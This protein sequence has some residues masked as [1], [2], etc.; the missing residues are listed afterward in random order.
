[1]SGQLE[2]IESGHGCGTTGAADAL[3][4]RGFRV[5]FGDQIVLLNVTL[6]LR[7]RGVLTLLGPG[8]AGKS[9]LLRTLAGLNDP[10]PALRTWGDV[11]V[12]G[13]PIDA[14][15][16]P[17]LVG[18]NAQ[19]LRSSVRENLVSVLASR[20]RWSK[21]EQTAW[22]TQQLREGGLETL[23]EVL[24]SDVLDLPLGLRRRLAIVRAVAAGRS[25]VMID[26]PTVGLDPEQASLTLDLISKVAARVAILLVTHNR[27]HARALGDRTALLA[28]GV[29][30]ECQPTER[31][32]RAPETE[33]G[34]SY[35]LNGS[36]A[37]AG[38]MAKPD[39]LAEGVKPPTLLPAPIRRSLSEATGPQGFY[40][41][42]QGKVGGLPRPGIVRD[43]RHDLEG[44]A[45][46]GVT[47]LITLEE[48]HTVPL[49][50][51]RAAGIDHVLFPI[52]D[53]QVPTIGDTVELFGAVSRRVDEGAV[54]AFHCLAGLGRTGTLLASWLIYCGASAPEA[55]EFVRKAQPRSVQSEAQEEFLDRFA[56]AIRA[57]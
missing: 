42:E 35:V 49:A 3:S 39:E 28:G 2:R 21:P 43:L 55:L 41:A 12:L 8:G 11:R 22:V 38:P 57:T 5:A 32:F 54:V 16:R 50:Q 31:F 56:T 30:Q 13:E 25:V 46:L 18:Q 1:M 19:L 29:I 24:D 51:L 52:P 17:T 26:E 36:C 6:A 53:M 9:T 4:L 33:A 34:R 37:V 20:D 10:Q 40:W 7:E 15:N 14:S 47:L 44:L 23:I 27:Q 48:T 45:R